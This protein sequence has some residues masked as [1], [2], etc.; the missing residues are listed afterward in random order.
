MK[1]LS[2]FNIFKPD[3]RPEIKDLVNYLNQNIIGRQSL[4]YNSHS[5]RE[6]NQMIM[7]PKV[8]FLKDGSQVVFEPY[9]DKND[10]YIILKGKTINLSKEEHYYVWV[11]ALFPISNKLYEIEK[12]KAAEEE[13]KLIQSLI[14]S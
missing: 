6:V 10:K 13:K 4:S 14:S 5:W 12:Q 2:W 9:S 11:K 8:Y 7:S 3:I 1:F